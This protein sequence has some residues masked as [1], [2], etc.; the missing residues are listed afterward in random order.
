VDVCEVKRDKICR[1][2]DKFLLTLW[3]KGYIIMEKDGKVV[4]A[5]YASMLLFT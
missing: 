3:R 5:G 2:R 4:P 1:K